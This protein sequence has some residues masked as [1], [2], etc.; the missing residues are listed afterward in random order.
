MGFGSLRG[1]GE[2][3]HTDDASGSHDIP[4]S[5]LQSL[6]LA[7]L[8]SMTPASGCGTPFIWV[9]SSMAMVGKWCRERWGE[10]E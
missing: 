10:D 6:S 5:T 7:M 2:K 1:L 4:L 3:S 9:A 8:L